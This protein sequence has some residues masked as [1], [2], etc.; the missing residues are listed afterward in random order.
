MTEKDLPDK[1]N[2]ET[3]GADPD[4]TPKQRAAYERH[5]TQ[6][7]AQLGDLGRRI[8]HLRMRKRWS[9]SDLARA[10]GLNKNLI[11]TTERG[12]TQPRIRN[13]AAI[14]SA[15]G[16]PAAELTGGLYDEDGTKSQAHPTVSAVEMPNNPNVVWVTI[17]RPVY[18][19]TAAK[20]YAALD[21]DDA[22]ENA[23]PAHRG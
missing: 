12:I 22:H 10:A 18:L 13:L 7:I 14:A 19:R 1:D 11:N 8:M 23:R 21:E 15:L 9:Q 4:W 16:V 2:L 5:R 20:I 3:D 6:R 17:N